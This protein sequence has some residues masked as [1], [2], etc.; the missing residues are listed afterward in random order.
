MS[1]DPCIIIGGSHAAVQAAASL[2]QEARENDIIVIGAEPH[3]SCQC[4]P[5][6]K[7]VLCGQTPLEKYFSVQ[8]LLR[9]AKYYFKPW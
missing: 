1:S 4:P 2:R 5:L 7:A 9:E 6:S 8:I 3:L